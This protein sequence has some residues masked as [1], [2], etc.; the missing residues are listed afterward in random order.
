[1]AGISGEVKAEILAKVKS[2]QK[3]TDL[4]KQYGV[5]TKTIYNWLRG[6]VTE[7]VSWREYKRVMKENEDLKN[8]LGVLTLDLEK[9]KKR[10][11]EFV[12]K[13]LKNILKQTRSCCHR[14]WKFPVGE[15]TKGMLPN[16]TKMLCLK[17]KLLAVLAEH[18][19]YGYRRIALELEIG[20]KRIRRCMKLYGI[21]H[22]K[23]K[24]GGEKEEMRE[25]KQLHFQTRLKSISHCS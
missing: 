22:T 11:G 8:I 7:Q 25:E 6:Q 5:S 14:A 3:V 15:C 2:G 21:K 13:V 1:M 17:S 19:S 23:E 20:K 24:P 10:K 4:A 16:K 18:P 12:T 9:T